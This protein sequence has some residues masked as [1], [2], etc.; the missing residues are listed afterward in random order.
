MIK[1]VTGKDLTI[2]N[3]PR[4]EGDP[5]AIFADNSKIKKILNWEPQYSDLETIV[6]TAWAW[7]KSHPN[8]YQTK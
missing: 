3:N 2:I 6:K 5:A 8:G 7:H 4:R 1:K